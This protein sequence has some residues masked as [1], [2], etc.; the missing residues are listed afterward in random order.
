MA[1][2]S[3][4]EGRA[5]E[6]A[7]KWEAHYRARHVNAENAKFNRDSR[8]T[9]RCKPFAGPFAA[10]LLADARTQAR[11]EIEREEFEAA[12]IEA[13]DPAMVAELREAEINHACADRINVTAEW[14]EA[15]VATAAR[16]AAARAAVFGAGSLSAEVRAAARARLSETAN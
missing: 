1:T 8:M 3:Q 2:Q 11:A 5:A 6:L 4:I 10:E 16:L 14:R 12:A 7:A 9:Y 13:A 15:T